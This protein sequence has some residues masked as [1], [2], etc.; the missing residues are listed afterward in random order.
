MQSQV[1]Q[2]TLPVATE[3]DKRLERIKRQAAERQAAEKQAAETIVCVV[4]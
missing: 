2:H 1:E 4:F 3:A